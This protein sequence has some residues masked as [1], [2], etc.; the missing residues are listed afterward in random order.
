MDLASYRYLLALRYDL[1]SLFVGSE[2]TLGIVG[3]VTLK[4]VPVSRPCRF[5][6]TFAHLPSH[7]AQIP[8]ATAVAVCSFD[9]LSSAS[10]AVRAVVQKGIQVGCVELLDDVMI[11]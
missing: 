7:F 9:S 6:C 3:E 2:G 4:L 1:T 5:D 10:S 8:E 11:E